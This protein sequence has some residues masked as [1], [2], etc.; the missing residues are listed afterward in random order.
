VRS[1]LVSMKSGGPRRSN[2][3]AQPAARGHGH[4]VPRTPA[5]ARV[6]AVALRVRLESF[7][8]ALEHATSLRV[9]AV[10][11]RDYAALLDSVSARK[12]DLA[13]LPP[14]MAVRAVE[15]RVATPLL[16]PVRDGSSVF[17]SVLFCRRIALSAH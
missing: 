11:Y 2:A 3:L 13:W 16:M 10:T 9:V 12:V 1:M 6:A 14:L 17:W 4:S 5:S 15:E 7:C 8:A